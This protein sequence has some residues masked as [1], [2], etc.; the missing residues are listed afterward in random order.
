[1]PTF[2]PGDHLVLNIDLIGLTEHH[3]LFVGNEQVIHLSKDGVIREEPLR[4]FAAGQQVRA[5]RSADDAPLAI[6]RGRSQLG[7]TGYQLF[8]NN[9]EHFVNWCLDLAHSSDQI[10]NLLHLTAQGVAHSGL[11]GEFAKRAASTP[12][13]QVAL[14]STTTK[15]AADYLGAPKPVSTLLG[16]PGDM[17]GK[18]L[19]SLVIGSAQTLAETSQLLAQGD[20]GQAASQLVAGTAKTVVNAAIVTPVSVAGNAVKA[21]VDLGRDFWWWLKH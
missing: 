5:I 11:A 3:G 13:A 16:T 9:C 7:Q 14:I 15:M 8:H 2:Y 6:A 19:E 17:I 20:Y 12:F 4:V 1:M 18:P 21:G 10:S